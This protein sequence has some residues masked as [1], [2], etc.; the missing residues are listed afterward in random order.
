MYAPHDIFGIK[1]VEWKNC[2]F[3]QNKEVHLRCY[4]WIVQ[5]IRLF[6]SLQGEENEN[7]YYAYSRV[8]IFVSY[9]DPGYRSRETLII[10]KINPPPHT[11]THVEIANS[12][13]VFN[14]HEF[15]ILWLFTKCRIR[16]FSFFFSGAIIIIIFARFSW[17]LANITSTTVLEFRLY[18]VHLLLKQSAIQ[19]SCL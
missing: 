8:I 9:C 19:L 14:F 17:N 2:R 15:L 11:H 4:T 3:R 1:S 7:K 5:K 6:Y 12:T 16:E 10:S 18:S 13:H